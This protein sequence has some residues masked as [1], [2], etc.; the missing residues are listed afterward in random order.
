MVEDVP[1][2]EACLPGQPR[3]E[4][5]RLA[6]GL[7]RRMSAGAAAVAT[8]ASGARI[9]TR[10]RGNEIE[11]AA[12]ALRQSR[13]R[14]VSAQTVVAGPTRRPTHRA[15]LFPREALEMRWR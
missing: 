13:L 12:S 6:G 3:R 15:L 11:E 9:T 4:S 5:P 10:C 8:M 14:R 7:L 2:G 1:Q